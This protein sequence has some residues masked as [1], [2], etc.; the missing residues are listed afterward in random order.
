[1]GFKES[2]EKLYDMTCT[3]SAK[4]KTTL[5]TGETVF[6]DSV[7]YE[8][9]PCRI[10]FSSFANGIKDRVKTAPSGSVKL[11]TSTEYDIPDGARVV[12]TFQGRTFKYRYAGVS[13]V[14]RFHQEVNLELDKDFS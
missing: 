5:E 8:N 9:V 11:F 14:Y 4:T 7:L 3:I 6:T 12:V 2:I 13:A 10:S 1:M